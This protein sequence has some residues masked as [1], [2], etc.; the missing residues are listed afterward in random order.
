[1]ANQR[2]ELSDTTPEDDPELVA[3]FDLAGA[4]DTFYRAASKVP[5][6]EFLFDVEDDPI[7]PDDDF[8]FTDKQGDAASLHGHVECERAWRTHS[9]L[10]TVAS[11]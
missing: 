3:V 7:D 5:G 8:Y 9:T 4:V 2:V 1:L 10:R 11:E 6:L